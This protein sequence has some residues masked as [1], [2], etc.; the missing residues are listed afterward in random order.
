MNFDMILNSAEKCT[1]DSSYSTLEVISSR[2]NNIIT[3]CEGGSD[4][5][6]KAFGLQMQ[7]NN[8]ISTKKELDTKRGIEKHEKKMSNWSENRTKRGD[9]FIN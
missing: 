3:S 6:K 7:V 4:L 1:I 2:L 9:V 8:L 5:F